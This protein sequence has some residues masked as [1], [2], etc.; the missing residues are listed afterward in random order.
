MDENLS[1]Q[2]GEHQASV[3]TENRIETITRNSYTFWILTYEPSGCVDVV[4]K[5]NHHL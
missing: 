4:F 3:I 5:V 1:R 2:H